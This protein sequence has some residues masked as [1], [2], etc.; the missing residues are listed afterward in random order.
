MILSLAAG[1]AT[2]AQTAASTWT[3]I[4]SLSA[5]LGGAVAGITPQ[6]A[7]SLDAAQKAAAKHLANIDKRID[8]LAKDIGDVIN[9]AAARGKKK[10]PKGGK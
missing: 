4:N 8:H 9:G 5:T 1:D 7:T 10:N 6:G 3:D 2:T